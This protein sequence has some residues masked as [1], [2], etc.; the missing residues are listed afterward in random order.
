LK[1]GIVWNISA[2]PFRIIGKNRNGTHVCETICILFFYVL[3]FFPPNFSFVFW[4]NEIL[5]GKSVL[6][7]RVNLLCKESF[8]GFN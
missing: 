1:I 7:K 3:N 6:F 2:S 4:K 8:S 5:A